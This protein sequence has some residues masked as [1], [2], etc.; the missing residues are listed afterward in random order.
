MCAGPTDGNETGSEGGIPRSRSR[1]SDCRDR[2]GGGYTRILGRDQN[3]FIRRANG[4]PREF[5][6]SLQLLGAG[7]VPIELGGAGALL[8]REYQDLGQNIPRNH[9]PVRAMKFRLLAG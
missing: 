1:R 7:V 9:L 8:L 3:P 4:P 5:S 2:G 6:V